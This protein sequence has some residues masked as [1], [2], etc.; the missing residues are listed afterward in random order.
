LRLCN[1]L[2]RIPKQKEINASPIL[3]ASSTLR[4][5]F[6]RNIG[7][8]YNDFCN[9]YGYHNSKEQIYTIET[10]KNSWERF[11]IKFG[12]F[13][14][15]KDYCNSEFGIPS[16]E[17]IMQILGNSKEE[18][19]NGFKERE[20]KYNFT[21]KCKELKDYCIEN[22]LI[23]KGEEL[24]KH[25]FPNYRWFVNHSPDNIK[26]Y[27]EFLTSLGL[28]PHKNAT[29]ELAIKSIMDKY[30]KLDRPLKYLD[31]YDPKFNE[32]GIRTV[33]N[34]WGTFNNM[35]KE[36][37]LPI[38]QESMS[39][40]HKTLD[41]LEHDIK[42]LCNHIYDIKGRKNISLEDID[43]CEW[44]LHSGTYNRYFKEELDMTI[45]E[46]IKSIGFIPNESGM[47]MNFVF[48]DGEATT[49]QY[50]FATSKYFRDNGIK[51]SRNVKY[52]LFIDTYK[53]NKDCDYVVNINN[54]NWYIEIA[55]MLNYEKIDTNKLKGYHKEYKIHIDEKE[56]MLKSNNLNYKILYPTDFGKSL[57][58]VFSFLSSNIL[59]Y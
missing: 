50:E 29:K 38:N 40:K 7:I 39:D 28:N 14:K 43:N 46:Y 8:S 33:T 26:S 11:Y 58:D 19:F 56:N 23:L 36:L 18:F 20:D 57:S 59:R 6:K 51:Y 37:N 31:F 25:S 54:T 5:I 47:G 35:L 34:I 42:E 15:S 32:V 27:G 10:L 53:G 12:R 9:S 13:P 48:E 1:Q 30:K 41:E 21:L 45:G 2:G 44:C 52:N 17:I 24:S 16:H 55:G 3:P 49:S 4:D 22:K